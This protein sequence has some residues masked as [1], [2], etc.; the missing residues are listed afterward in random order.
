MAILRD[1]DFLTQRQIIHAERLTVSNAQS[2]HDVID[3]IRFSFIVALQPVEHMLFCLRCIV[4]QIPRYKLWAVLHVY[5][6]QFFPF[7]SKCLVFSDDYCAEQYSAQC[8][9]QAAA[10]HI[11]TAIGILDR[12]EY[13]FFALLLDHRIAAVHRV[14]DPRH[15]LPLG[16]TVILQPVNKVD[17]TVQ[18]VL[19]IRREQA[20]F[21]KICKHFL[22]IRDMH[23]VR[24]SVVNIFLFPDRATT[25][26]KYRSLC[27]ERDRIVL[28]FFSHSYISI[29]SGAA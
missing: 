8:A 29:H 19:F 28:Q 22:H 18:Q 27:V 11:R 7:F 13:L 16:D 26:D 15:K 20:T 1:V 24:V 4:L 14:R 5:I 10:R 2:A 25:A 12:R 3:R 23:F 6:Q 21:H 17:F 9:L